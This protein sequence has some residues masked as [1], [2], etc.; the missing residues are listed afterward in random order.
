MAKQSKRA[1]R[2]AIVEQMRREQKRKERR[3]SFAVVGAATAVGAVIVG[4]AVWQT[5][6]ADN[7]SGGDL[8][9]LGVA[10]SDAGCQEIT[11][12]PAKGNN[13]HRTEGERI[14]YEATPPATGPHWAK[15]LIGNE[16]RPFWTTDDRPPVERLVH[17]LE[18]G[19]TI[20]WYDETLAEDDES[21]G[22]LESVATKAAATDGARGKFMVAPWTAQDGGELPDGTHVALTHWSMGGTQGNPQGQLGVWQYCADVSGE[23]VQ[24]FI[25]DYPS[26]DSPEPNAA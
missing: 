18:H 22:V 8:A 4:F 17:S 12:A 26:S 15:F 14:P 24:D 16:I 9:T 5:V 1:D 3:Q 11:T 13:D 25:A 21:S 7:E 23:V 19:H 2:R 20:L 10:A 6:S